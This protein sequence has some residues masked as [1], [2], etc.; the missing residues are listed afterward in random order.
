M[1]SIIFKLIF[2]VSLTVCKPR[3]HELSRAEPRLFLGGGEKEDDSYND[4]YD[5]YFDYGYYGGE[6][7][8]GGHHFM[9]RNIRENE[10]FGSDLINF[11]LADFLEDLLS[12]L[13]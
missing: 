10:G 9:D 7:H 1:F 4:F 11:S 3:Y 6:H 2:L 13:R 8:G 5:P 12:N